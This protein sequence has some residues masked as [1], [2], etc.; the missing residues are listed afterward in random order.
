MT[1]RR[2]RRQTLIENGLLLVWIHIAWRSFDQDT[3]AGA[4]LLIGWA[5]VTAWAHWLA[6][7][8]APG[9]AEGANETAAGLAGAVI[10]ALA[11]WAAPEGSGTGT[12]STLLIAAGAAMTVSGIAGRWWE[13]LKQR[14]E[15]RIGRAIPKE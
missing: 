7:S 4:G 10:G 2:W 1:K 3:E 11:A 9:A 6:R 15:K 5:A 13:G 12:V 8:K 14:M